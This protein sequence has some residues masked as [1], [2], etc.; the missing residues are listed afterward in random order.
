MQN[1]LTLDQY[2]QSMAEFEPEINPIGAV[3]CARLQYS[4]LDH[5]SRDTLQSEAALARECEI[6]EPGALR[7]IAATYDQQDRFDLWE[8][9]KP[10]PAP[11]ESFIVLEI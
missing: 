4:T 2:E 10:T 8:E 1:T 9:R 5:L 6:A 3:C 7:R 11:P